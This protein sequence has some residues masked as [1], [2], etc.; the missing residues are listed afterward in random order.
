MLDWMKQTCDKSISGDF[1]I[2]LF[3]HVSKI[4]NEKELEELIVVNEK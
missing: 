2:H 1:E 3:V 4:E